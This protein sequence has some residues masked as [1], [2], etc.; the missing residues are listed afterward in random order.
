MN[1]GHLSVL[2]KKQPRHAQS[3]EIGV[4]NAVTDNGPRTDSTRL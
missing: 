3:P 4:A 2:G 1:N